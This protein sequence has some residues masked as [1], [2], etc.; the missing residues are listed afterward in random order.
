[1][2]F[3]YLPIQAMHQAPEHEAE[4]EAH[5]AEPP[6]GPAPGERLA[7]HNGYGPTLNG[8]AGPPLFSFGSLYLVGRRESVQMQP[9]QVCP[10]H[11]S[12]LI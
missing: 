7:I 4:R 1:M 8:Y 9:K 2:V 5:A 12:L 6:A 10:L 11:V 3:I